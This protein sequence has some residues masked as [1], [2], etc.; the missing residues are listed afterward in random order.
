MNRYPRCKSNPLVPA[1]C[2]C[3]LNCLYSIAK[4]ELQGIVAAQVT[5]AA[6]ACINCLLGP[7]VFLAMLAMPGLCCFLR[8]TLFEMYAAFRCDFHQWFM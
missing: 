1:G 3:N 6:C 5:H 8:V 7:L 4:G 2:L